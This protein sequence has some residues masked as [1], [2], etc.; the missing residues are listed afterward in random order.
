[1]YT[2]RKKYRL[3]PGS[4]F[5]I[6]LF[7]LI[8]TGM[9]YLIY[10]DKGKFWD[11]LPFISIPAIVISLVLIIFNF[12]RRTIGSTCFIFFFILFLTGL[13]LSN[14]F[15]PTALIYKAEKSLANRNYEESIGYYKT[16]LNNYP[17]SRLSA[18]ALENISFAYY[19]NKDYLEAIDS[20]KNAID[21]EIFTSRDLKIKNILVECHSKL[22][23]EYFEEKE[24][25]KSAESYLDAVEILEEIKINFPA[26]NDAFIAIYKIPEHLYNAALNFNRDRNWDK[27]IETL[28]YLISDYN[29]SDYFDKAGYLFYEVCI[30]KST[31]L[32][33][34]HKYI[35]G[36]ETFLNILNLN[37]TNSEYNNV[38]NYEKKRIFSSIPSYILKDI[39][40]DNYNS[41]NY[42][43][44]LFLC[45]IIEDYNPQQ[46]EEVGPLLIDSKINLVS[47]TD[48]NPFEPPDPE[49]KFRGPGKSILA[50]ENNTEF[51]LTIYLKGPEYKLIRVEKNSKVE[52][53]ISAGTYEAVS[54]SSNP[55][56]L[57]DYGNLTYEEGQ[58]YRYEYLST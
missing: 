52:I 1:M 40:L 51:V 48:Y 41:G 24:Y 17:S 42:R 16:L 38:S 10:I 28:D 21:S 56:I 54:E 43:S 46:E 4:I 20:Y 27:S 49:R 15:G 23:E 33:E 57:P 19:S 5:F 58:R 35:E 39:A 53:E 11:L 3:D 55:D 31:A 32:I 9:G 7:T 37:G 22:A 25:G 30:K 13:I 18:S 12:I 47:S 8:I 44:S 45:E 36:V 29:D 50:I 2:Y 34:S 6:V 14:I 26:T